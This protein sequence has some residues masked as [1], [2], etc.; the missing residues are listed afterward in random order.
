[1]DWQ[2][3]RLV[4]VEWE[5]AASVDQWESL[6]DVMSEKKRLNSVK[7][8]GFVIEETLEHILIG[9]NIDVDGENI[10]GRVAIPCSCIVKVV[11]LCPSQKT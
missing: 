11:D 8:A 5:D 4:L 9:Q 6:T 1:M 3:L 2:N 10:A 7:T